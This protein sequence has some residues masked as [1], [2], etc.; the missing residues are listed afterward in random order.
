L[1]KFLQACAC[2]AFALI[3]GMADAGMADAVMTVEIC[4]AMLN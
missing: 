3:K 2:F 4:T 1:Q